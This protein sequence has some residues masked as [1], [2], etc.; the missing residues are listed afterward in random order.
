MRTGLTEPDAG[1]SGSQVPGE[2]RQRGFW[3]IVLVGPM[4]VSLEQQTDRDLLVETELAPL[5]NERGDW[6]CQI[7]HHTD[8]VF[9]SR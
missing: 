1:D 8:H 2:N 6:A 9:G 5:A 3:I 7:T 4:L